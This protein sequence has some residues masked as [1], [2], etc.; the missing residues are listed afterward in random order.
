MVT[1]LAWLY[2]SL[3]ASTP[4][5]WLEIWVGAWWLLE[6][7]GP[8]TSQFAGLLFSKHPGDLFGWLPLMVIFTIACGSLSLLRHLPHTHLLVMGLIV[9]KNSSAN[10][11]SGFIISNEDLKKTYFRFQHLHLFIKAG[12]R[13]SDW[14][15]GII[16]A[17]PQILFSSIF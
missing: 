6:E 14:S 17:A 11:L 12:L 2:N 5:C 4:G 8:L 15:W 13:R 10:K 7:P 3:T 16:A 9:Q 1:L